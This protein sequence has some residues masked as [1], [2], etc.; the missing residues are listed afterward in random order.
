MFKSAR[1]FAQ[2]SI[3]TLAAVFTLGAVGNA[4]AGDA[5]RGKEEAQVCASCHNAN[6]VSS[7]PQYPNIGGQAENYLIIA[8][9]QYREGA[10]PSD[11]NAKGGV[12]LKKL[13]RKNAIMAGFAGRLTDQ[14]IEDLAAWYSSQDG[15]LFTPTNW[16]D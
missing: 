10:A 5:A 12:A 2:H 14:Q 8:L 6:G 15:G 4:V 7:S 11:T 3:V 1:P 9:K 16:N 13:A